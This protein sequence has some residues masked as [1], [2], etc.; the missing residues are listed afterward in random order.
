MAVG[1]PAQR[2][3]TTMASYIQPSSRFGVDTRIRLSPCSGLT[4]ALQ[5]PHRPV[6][7]A[8]SGLTLGAV[9]FR[10][11]GPLEVVGEAGVVLAVGGPRE[12][13]LLA[14]LLLSVNQVV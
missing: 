1:E 2:A 14:R 4:G 8:G 11:L 12:R 13:A 3:P 7:A 5:R 9:E 10:V 6:T